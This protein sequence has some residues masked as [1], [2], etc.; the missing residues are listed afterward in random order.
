V[1]AGTVLNQTG[2]A[3]EVILITMGVYLTISLLT[4]VA[5]NYYN[6]RKALVER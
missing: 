2:Q 5:M 4:S 3:I 1:F 6:S